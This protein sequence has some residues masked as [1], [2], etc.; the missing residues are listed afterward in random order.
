MDKQT[1][2]RQIC[3]KADHY[4]A[5]KNYVLAKKEYAHALQLAPS[6]EISAR[7]R[8]CEE[9]LALQ[10]RKELIKKGRRLEKKG[11]LAAALD[12]FSQA[13]EGEHEEW[14]E[15]KVEQLGRRRREDQAEALIE[16]IGGMTGKATPAERLAACERALEL[17]QDDRLRQEKLGCLVQLGRYSESIALFEERAVDGDQGRYDYGY[18]LIASGRYLQGLDQ[19]TTLSSAHPALLPQ[20]EACLPGLAGELA[21]GGGSYALPYHL[22]DGLPAAERTPA[23]ERYRCYFTCRYLEQLW[24]A[25]DHA[26]IRE[27]LPSLPEPT[28][29]PL[30]G[31]L[32]RLYF[33][34]AGDDVRWLEPAISYWL[35]AI[36][37]QELLQSLQIH[38]AVPDAPDNRSI[39][40]GLLKLMEER[41][42]THA[43][44]GRLTP[45]LEAHWQ[46][47][48]RQIERLAALPVDSGGLAVFPCTPAFA[49]RFA[50]SEPILDLLRAQRPGL[51]LDDPA[52]LEL[53]AHY[54]PLGH[55][56]VRIEA[57]SEEKVFN[58]LPPPGADPLSG[59]LR[60]C[61]ALGCGISRV[62]NGERQ[63]R[64]YFQAALPL[65]EDTPHFQQQLIDL[66]YSEPAEK[67]LSSL[68]EAME[69]LS[70][71]LQEADFLQA[72]A[73][74]VAA[75]AETL[76][77]RGV[78]PASVEKRL[79][80]ALAIYPDSH[81]AKSLL[82][83]VR[84]EQTFERIHKAFRG[85]DTTKVANIV[86]DSADPEVKGYFF[87]TMEHWRQGLVSKDKTR[88]IGQL[89]SMYRNCFSIDKEHP[90]TLKIA[91][92]LKQLEAG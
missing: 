63:T 60:Q 82:A 61:V 5:R 21:S 2:H 66:A 13:L 77:Q 53:S 75:D 34:L 91:A 87:N 43:R 57:G 12:C 4:F 92:D 74:C 86:R 40:A 65:L 54:S 14:L 46:A 6:D 19:W 49:R 26:R 55:Y 84:R 8:A 33:S 62:R 69:F 45:A 51:G 1:Q 90:I 70:R 48:R 64:K 50:L 10:K 59:Y 20:V 23:L 25:G 31:L 37:N 52:W 81:Q 35:T 83:A 80:K 9:Q 7:I 16:Q 88:Q 79:K 85:G 22:L 38:G 73:H 42:D 32:A 89:N 67:I 72:A 39:R 36:Y 76:L 27:L 15:K 71:H 3:A 30:L 11:D 58:A 41:V 47:E 56:L 17:G 78:N 68:A 29:P 44:A 28:T 18:A 24:Y